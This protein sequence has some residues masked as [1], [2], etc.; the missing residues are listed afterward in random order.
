MNIDYFKLFEPFIVMAIF[1]TA[2]WEPKFPKRRR[3]E[4]KPND[5]TA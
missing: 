4:A 3:K 5:R 1:M 2:L